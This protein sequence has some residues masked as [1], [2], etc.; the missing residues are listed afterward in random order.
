M[1]YCVWVMPSCR[2]L[3]QSQMGMGFSMREITWVMLWVVREEVL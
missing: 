3:V 1:W 2:Y